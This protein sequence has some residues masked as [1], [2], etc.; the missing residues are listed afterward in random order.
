MAVNELVTIY[1]NETKLASSVSNVDCND[2][3]LE[4]MNAEKLR[5]WLTNTFAGKITLTKLPKQLVKAL[6]S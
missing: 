4:N 5:W 1:Q 6:P 2:G 3:L